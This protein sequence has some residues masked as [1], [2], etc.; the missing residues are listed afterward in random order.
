MVT[1]LKMMVANYIVISPKYRYDVAL[2]Y[3]KQVDYDLGAAIAA[4]KDD[5]IWERE[6]PME[7]I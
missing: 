6:H 4:Y 5:E 7:G 2:L 1:I 3:L